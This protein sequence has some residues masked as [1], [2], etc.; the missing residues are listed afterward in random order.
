VFPFLLV[1]MSPKSLAVVLPP[2]SSLLIMPFLGFPL[3]LLLS[4]PSSLYFILEEILICLLKLA[5]CLSKPSDSPLNSA[6]CTA[7]TPVPFVPNTAV[8]K[9]EGRWSEVSS[10]DPCI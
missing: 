6:H 7:S 1:S 8:I 9:R 5:K 2:C 3:V 10:K 4:L